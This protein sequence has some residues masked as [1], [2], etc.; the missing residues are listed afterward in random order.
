MLLA[1][2]AKVDMVE[3]FVVDL[4]QVLLQQTE[5]GFLI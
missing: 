2:P 1:V 4:Q 3:S 5:V